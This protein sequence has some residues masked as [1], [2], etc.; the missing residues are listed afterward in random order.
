M[1]RET[2][3]NKQTK[4]LTNVKGKKNQTNWGFI[5]NQLSRNKQ[6]INYRH[7]ILK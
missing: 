5:T 6:D 4:I 2:S 3:A 1:Q 7:L